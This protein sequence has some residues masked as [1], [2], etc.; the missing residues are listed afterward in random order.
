MSKFQERS[1]RIEPL[2]SILLPVTFIP[3]I[4]SRT[5]GI[6]GSDN[7]DNCSSNSNSN[8]TGDPRQRKH[9]L[10][11]SNT[12]TSNRKPLSK[13]VI[14]DLTNLINSSSGP[15]MDPKNPLNHNPNHIHYHNPLKSHDIHSSHELP[16]ETNIHH[17]QH[18]HHVTTEVVAYTSLGSK[19][20]TVNATALRSNLYHL[21]HTI[22]FYTD[23]YV[24][25]GGDLLVDQGRL[26]YVFANQEKR[27]LQ[28][29]QQQQNVP[30]KEINLI[31]LLIIQM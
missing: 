20:I 6:S 22:S 18:L 3:R 17:L 10:N 5:I 31:D 16:P 15:R 4:P 25:S 2:S 1:V 21:P 27:K 14:A 11:H 19:H 24:S 13:A 23:G 29:Q 7:G 8:D 26:N 30:Q 28:Q 9:D 12:N